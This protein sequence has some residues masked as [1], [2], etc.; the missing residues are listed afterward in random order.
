MNP[1]T[2]KE[3]NVIPMS[4]LHFSLPETINGLSNIAITIEYAQFDEMPETVHCWAWAQVGAA[5]FLRGLVDEYDVPYDANEDELIQ[6][7]VSKLNSSG[8]FTDS[9]PGFIESI[10]EQDPESANQ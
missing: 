3:M 7:I 9:L 10:L 1:F 5:A 8:R 4:C 2:F 6:T